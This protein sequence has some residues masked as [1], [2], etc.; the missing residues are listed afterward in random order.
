MWPHSGSDPEKPVSRVPL[1]RR[2]EMR[3]GPLL[4][5]VRVDSREPDSSV[6]ELT[7]PGLVLASFCRQQ[8]PDDLQWRHHDRIIVRSVPKIRKGFAP[9]SAGPRA[10][11]AVWVF[12]GADQP[13]RYE[14]RS[15]RPKPAF[16][17]VILDGDR[18]SD[19]RYLEI[20]ASSC[21]EDATLDWGWPPT[22]GSGP[23]ALATPCTYVPGRYSGPSKFKS[24]VAHPWNWDIGSSTSAAWTSLNMVLTDRCAKSLTFGAD[25]HRKSW[26]PVQEE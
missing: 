4:G 20:S 26:R 1:R 2:P 16:R 25:G 19:G 7:A 10:W 18:R 24:R 11:Q 6:G 14:H 23:F 5:R 9:A 8:P 15:H 13:Q 12:P 17:K 21:P 3:N 22:Y